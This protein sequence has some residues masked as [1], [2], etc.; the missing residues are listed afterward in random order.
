VEAA[1]AAAPRERPARAG[2][3]LR[4]AAQASGAATPAM[5]AH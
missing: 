5:V 4:M 3:E 2:L 1:L